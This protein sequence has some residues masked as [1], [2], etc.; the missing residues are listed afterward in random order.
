MKR[1]IKNKTAARSWMTLERRR[2]VW[3]YIFLSPWLLGLM[4]VFIVPMILSLTFAFSKVTVD[5]GYSLAFIGLD[6]FQEALLRDANFLQYF[7]A[8]MGDMLYNVPI[9]LVYSFLVAVFLKEN[10]RGVTVFKFIFFLP[11]ILSSDLFLSLINNFGTATTTS[12][13]AVMSSA[14]ST[15]LLKSLN[16][17]DYLVQLGLS[18][19]VVKTLTGPVD[20]VYEIV[21]CSGIQIFIFLAAINAVPPSLYEAAHVEGATGWEKFWKITFPMV[22]PMILVNVVY[23]VVDTFMSQN[24]LVMEYVYT[25]SFKNFNFGLSSAICWLYFAALAVILALVFWIV[26]KRTFY[27]T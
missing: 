12:L 16:L 26:S 23:S 9:I 1:S 27:Y 14:S 17:S 18:E 11:V 22:T 5:N 13:D 20:K 3:G 24:N 7:A 4:L 15:S 6:N 8:T 19:Q 2:S 21:T 10:F 25:L